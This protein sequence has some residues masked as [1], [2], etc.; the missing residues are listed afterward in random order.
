M[1]IEEDVNSLDSHLERSDEYHFDLEKTESCAACKLPSQNL[2]CAI[3]NQSIHAGSA[4]SVAAGAE[5]YGDKRICKECYGDS[6]KCEIL[7][8]QACENWKGQ[9]IEAKKRSRG[10]YLGARKHEIK[11]MLKFE[12][13]KKIPILKNGSVLGLQLIKLQDT[14]ITLTNTCAFDSLYQIF[15][16]ASSDNADLQEYVEANSDKNYVFQLIEYTMKMRKI[17]TKSYTLRAVAIINALNVTLAKGNIQEIDA[18]CNIANLYEKLFE[19]QPTVIKQS[20]CCNI[21]TK[22]CIPLLGDQIIFADNL[23]NL[24][25]ST[26]TEGGRTCPGCNKWKNISWEIL[27]TGTA[28]FTCGYLIKDAM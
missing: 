26:I 24:P 17:T 9:A 16:A 21:V 27:R 28:K 23:G 1:S 22:K 4:C 14:K 20:Q 12:N 5:E 19:H 7:P 11:D 18:A 15:L 10:R 13:P 6:K 2:Q 25:I 3:C 8:L